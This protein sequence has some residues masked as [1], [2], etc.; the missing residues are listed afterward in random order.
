MC[1]AFGQFDRFI[2]WQT[3][4]FGM[5]TAD[6]DHTEPFTERSTAPQSPY[7]N[8]DVGIGFIILLIAIALVY[9]VPVLLL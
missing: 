7:T 2:V 6:S 5:T 1:V 4:K 9:G 3:K 8:R